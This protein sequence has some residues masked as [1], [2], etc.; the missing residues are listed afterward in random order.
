M[1][2]IQKSLVL[3]NQL[4]KLTIVEEPIPNQG[5]INNLQGTIL[6]IRLGLNFDQVVTNSAMTHVLVL[7][8]KMRRNEQLR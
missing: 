3:C 8:A 7:S 2:N 4:C 5:S 1:E 6:L